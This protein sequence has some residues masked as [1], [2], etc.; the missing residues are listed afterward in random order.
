MT[1]EKRL[2]S[3]ILVSEFVV[4][5]KEMVPSIPVWETVSPT[6]GIPSPEDTGSPTVEPT[7]SISG[8]GMDSIIGSPYWERV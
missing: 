6:T 5:E 4:F 2:E 3:F 1:T 8:E 7:I